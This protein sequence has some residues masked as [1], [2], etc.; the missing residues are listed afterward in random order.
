[1]NKSFDV[2][3]YLDENLVR[4][5]SSL[6][7]TGFIETI[8]KTQ[9]FDRTI[10]A[11]YHQGDKIESSNQGS[12]SRIER[13]GFRDKNRLDAS[14][15]FFNHHVD[16]DI[17]ARQCIR[18]ERQVK[19]TY[20]TFV[21]NG[22]LM[23]YF[24]ENNHLHRKNEDDIENNNI[25]PGDLIE[26][27]GTITNKGIISYIDTL[28]NLITIFGAEYLDALAKDCIGKINFSILLKML[29][30]IKSILSHN[31]TVDLI[32]KSGNGTVVL[33]VN[34][35]NFMNNQYSV[36]D[37][38]NCHCKVVGKVIKTCT[39]ECD[40]I[41]LLRKTGQE[42]FFEK[43]FEKCIPLLE[44]LRSNDILVPECPDLRINECAIQIMPLNI[45][46]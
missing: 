31:N 3:V 38:I 36:F 19:T 34:K 43:F 29:T 11:G 32:M 39:E 4:N 14:N 10:S 22:N 24:N 26:I 20:T 37:N 21:L 1:M 46:M 12:I 18:E 16:N 9:A 7:L 45:Y 44:C 25:Y 6:V 30:Y 41:S 15:N 23:N 17:D 2:L 13:K 28:I 42:E 27:E 5:L 40:T 8:T 35:D 33:T